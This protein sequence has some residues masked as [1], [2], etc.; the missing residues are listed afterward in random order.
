MKRGIESPR[1]IHNT[2]Q[3]MIP[4]GA[5]PGIT[6]FTRAVLKPTQVIFI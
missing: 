2:T 6:G 3:V 1:H 5:I 4:S